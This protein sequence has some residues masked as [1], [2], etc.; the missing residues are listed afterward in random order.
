MGTQAENIR[1]GMAKG[2][3][4]QFYRTRKGESN[5]NAIFST[6]AVL[7]IR[8][9]AAA[10]ETLAALGRDYGI[11]RQTIW[12]IVRRQNWKEVA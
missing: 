8:K 3:M 1:D 6:A 7:E 10:G 9:R 4:T 11:R 2:R 12:A 5:T